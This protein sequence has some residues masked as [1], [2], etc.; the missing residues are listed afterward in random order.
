MRDTSPDRRPDRWFGR[1]GTPETWDPLRR[2]GV[3]SLVMGVTVLV[4]SNLSGSTR[5][6]ILFARVA[7]S[8]TAGIAVYGAVVIFLGRRYEARNR[9]A[10]RQE[11]RRLVAHQRSTS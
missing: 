11:T 5:G 2:V 7:G 4:V 10:R 8:I 6:W 9:Q 1:L 3:A